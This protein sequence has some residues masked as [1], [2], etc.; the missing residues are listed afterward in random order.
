M[1]ANEIR[2]GN[3]FKFIG[4]ELPTHI[5]DT[6]IFQWNEDCWYY[7][8]EGGNMLEK[9]EPIALT[10]EWLL[11]FGY[12]ENNENYTWVIEN[13]DVEIDVFA[14]RV[15]FFY[16]H[17]KLQFVHQLQNLFYALTDEELTIK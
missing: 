10:E 12:I 8:L 15:G 13:H 3:W 7:E 4:K 17:H 5:L 1:K 14:R 11:K 16:R 9:T 2:L 6:D